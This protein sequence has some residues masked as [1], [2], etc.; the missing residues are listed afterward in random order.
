MYQY[1]SR[2]TYWMR[3]YGGLFNVTSLPINDNFECITALCRD[4][5]IAHIHYP[6]LILFRD[7]NVLLNGQYLLIPMTKLP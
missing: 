1:T 7:N 2:K 6:Y 3:M 4:R 5:R